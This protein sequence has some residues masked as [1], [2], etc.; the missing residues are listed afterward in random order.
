MITIEDEGSGIP[1]S[2][3]EK[4]FEPFYRIGSAHD[5]STGGVGLGLSVTR[6]IVWEHGGD[7]VLGNRKSGGLSVRLE[8]PSSIGSNLRPRV[9]TRY[10]GQSQTP[11]E[12]TPTA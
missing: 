8:L 1:R 5:P 11:D 3:W 7:I 6:S 12:G 9:E 2:E 10:R 4:V